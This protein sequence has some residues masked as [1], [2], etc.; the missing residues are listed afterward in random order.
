MG[1]LYIDR[2]DCHI[3]IDG[4]ALAFYID[5]KR[6][7]IVPIG[8]IKRAIFVGNMTLETSVLKKFS[9]LGIKAIFLSGKRLRFCGMLQGRLHYNGLLRL[10]QYEKTKTDF[11]S[12]FST[13]IVK[14]KIESQV[15]LL[16]ES[17]QR[18][19]DLR[20]YLL[21]AINSLKKRLERFG[22]DIF[23]IESLKGLEGSASAIYFSAYTRLFP[24]SLGF[25]KRTRRPPLDPVNAMLSLCYTL[26]HF[27]LVRE[28]EIIGLD[29]TIGYY[30]Q[31]D[32]GRESLACD[33][34]EIFRHEV[35]RFIWHIFRTRELSADGFSR[36]PKDNGCYLKKEKRK[37]FYHIY[38]EWAKDIRPLLTK[39]VRSVA[40][41]I[42]DSKDTLPE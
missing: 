26:L 18:R 32:Y 38:E 4:N 13:E 40:R 9:E 24:D 6:E 8:P 21:D 39:E 3:K 28:I 7:G 27:E 2:K 35:D 20:H 5:G 30:H 42:N 10:R 17:I 14:R 34:V 19:H 11:V 23:T 37:R 41:S 33:L 36:D 29:P 12:H 1:T 16:T 31:F 22:S 15:C 25:T